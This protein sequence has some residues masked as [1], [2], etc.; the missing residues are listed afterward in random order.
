MV[1]KE[2]IGEIV[3]KYQNPD[4]TLT[5]AGRLRYGVGSSRGRQLGGNGFG[6]GSSIIDTPENRKR[7][8]NEY[9]DSRADRVLNRVKYNPQSFG[10]KVFKRGDSRKVKERDKYER[11]GLERFKNQVAS[12]MISSSGK[13]IKTREDRE[14]AIK[15]AKAEMNDRA[16]DNAY[17]DAEYLYSKYSSN[18]HKC[19]KD[20]T[21]DD[22][23]K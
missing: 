18:A 21:D 11:I 6:S 17:Q 14:R 19:G 20:L 5:P 15:E 2:C 4:G 7:I 23:K 8:K 16:L 13:P 22:I 3:S 9:L 1:L 10:D 12:N